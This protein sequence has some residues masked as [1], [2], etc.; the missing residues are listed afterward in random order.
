MEAEAAEAE[1]AAKAARAETAAAE[2]AMEAHPSESIRQ[3]VGWVRGLQA[4]LDAAI[5]HGI[6]R[7]GLGRVVEATSAKTARHRS[8]QPPRP[9]R[10]C[11]PTRPACTLQPLGASLQ[12]HVT[13]ARKADLRV[14]SLRRALEALA[15]HET[16]GG[17]AA[18]DDAST[19]LDSALQEASLAMAADWRPTQQAD[20][21]AT[22]PAR[23]GEA[24]GP[25][26]TEALDSPPV[27]AA[28]AAAVPAAAASA[29][30]LDSFAAK[31]RLLREW[32][33][34]RPTPRASSSSS[35]EP[36]DR[37]PASRGPGDS[38]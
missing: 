5:D 21:P 27:A 11:D 10:G 2:A 9:T 15:P 1:A 28:V 13:Q 38:V 37:A 20:A 18:I 3:M 36:A 23:G 29:G 26:V 14:R 4:R 12:P 17:G 34:V 32:S 30:S 35:T 16:G 8:L 19:A 25:R 31:V 7:S 22:L 6:D 24:V 33:W